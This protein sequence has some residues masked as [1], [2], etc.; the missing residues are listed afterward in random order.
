MATDQNTSIQKDMITPEKIRAMNIEQ[1]NELYQGEIFGDLDENLI[2]LVKY[3]REDFIYARYTPEETAREQAHQAE[4]SQY[5]QENLELDCFSKFNSVVVDGFG[6][7]PW[8]NKIADDDIGAYQEILITIDSFR[9][10]KFRIFL[11]DMNPETEEIYKYRICFIK[12]SAGDTV[13]LDENIWT[14]E[15][16]EDLKEKIGS[17]FMEFEARNIMSCLSCIAS[18]PELMGLVL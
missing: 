11:H 5:L 12:I 15:D 9:Q 2:E 18:H 7:H 8:Q 10:I 1:L 14:P 13:L 17:T 6:R 16:L 4:L 3:R